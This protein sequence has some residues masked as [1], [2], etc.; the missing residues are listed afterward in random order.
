MNKEI[1]ELWVQALRSGEY[2]QGTGFLNKDGR[3][4][5]LGVLCEVLDKSKLMDI[6]K[7]AP[8]NSSFVSYRFIVNG[9]SSLWTSSSLPNNARNKARL[10]MYAVGELVRMNDFEDAD[11]DQIA[12]YIENN[13]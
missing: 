7:E 9:E 5:C 13:L 2:V 1:K 11:F 4:C 8:N 3:F 10:S 6:Y 12:D